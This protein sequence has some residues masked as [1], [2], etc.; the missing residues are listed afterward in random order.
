MIV[1]VVEQEYLILLIVVELK[2][3]VV[4]LV[5]IVLESWEGLHQDSESCKRHDF[6]HVH[7]PTLR[8]HCTSQ[9]HHKTN[10]CNECPQCFGS[11]YHKLH[12]V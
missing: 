11:N 1:L 3:L 9:S 7:S 12:D 4:V 6:Y 5:L 8:K 2:W 10:I